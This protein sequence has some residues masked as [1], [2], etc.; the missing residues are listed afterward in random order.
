M[1][2]VSAKIEIS[3]VAANNDSLEIWEAGII[4]VKLQ[5]ATFIPKKD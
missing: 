2:T 4:L 1:P 3:I 5:Q